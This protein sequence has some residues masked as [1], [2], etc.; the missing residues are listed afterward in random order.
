MYIEFLGGNKKIC[1]YLLFYVDLLCSKIVQV[2]VIKQ[3]NSKKSFTHPNRYILVYTQKMVFFNKCVIT[4]F[5][6]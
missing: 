1:K 2:Y 5:T 6:L 4:K 3:E